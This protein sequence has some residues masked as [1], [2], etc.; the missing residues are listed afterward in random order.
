[1]RWEDVGLDAGT[2]TVAGTLIQKGG[3]QAVFA[4]VLE[5]LAGS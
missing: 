3:W 1:M 4:D 5:G 2:V